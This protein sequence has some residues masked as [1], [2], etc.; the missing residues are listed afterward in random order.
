MHSKEKNAAIPEPLLQEL[1][2][3]RWFK[4]I[5]A[6]LQSLIVQRSVVRSYGR[7]QAIVS[8]GDATRGM[9]CVLKGRVRAVRFAKNG[10]E[11]LLD[12]GGVGYWFA[13][14][15]MLANA[16]SIGSV[17]ADTSVV[18]L[19][20]SERE[21]ARIV[22]REPRFYPHF[23]KLL[24]EQFARVFRHLGEV[25]G[26]TSEQLLLT[27]LKDMLDARQLEHTTNA[28]ADEIKVSQSD[29]ATM[30]GVSRQTLSALLARL[31]AEGRIE[32][33]YRRIRMLR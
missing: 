6:S 19:N 3:G 13:V 9:Y 16:P 30:V 11:V 23:A 31:E 28:G 33:G 18:V 4:E 2:R 12:V 10:E 7:N 29:L 26:L 22:E 27:R 21:F 1:Q 17:I 5:P 24:I 20:L 8:E 14:Y 15:G 32:I 25:Q